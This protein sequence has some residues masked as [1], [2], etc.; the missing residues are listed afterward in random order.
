[1]VNIFSLENC[2]AKQQED[3]VTH[4][5]EWQKSE[6]LKSPNASEGVEHQGLL[7]PCWWDL[8]TLKPLCKAVKWSYKIK[9]TIQQLHCLA[10]THEIKTYPHK[11]C[12]QI[13]TV[14]LFITTKAW[15][16]PICL[17]TGK[18]IN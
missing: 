12:T 4:S 10:I 15:K 8:K 18:Y 2:K 11:M 16:Q 14:V 7:I 5:F 6:T 1:M 9:L 17:S 13:H 3:I